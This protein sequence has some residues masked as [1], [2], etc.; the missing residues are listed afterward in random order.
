MEMERLSLARES[1]SSASRATKERSE[2]L[3]KDLAA[4]KE[5]QR[6]IAGQWESERSEMET[7]NQ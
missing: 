4:L 1:S 2:R 6:D 7:V 5:K 3:E